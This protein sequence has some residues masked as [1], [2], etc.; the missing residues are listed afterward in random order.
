[1]AQ[2]PLTAGKG[3]G[4]LRGYGRQRG[5]GKQHGPW[6]NDTVSVL[7]EWGAQRAS[8]W[9]SLGWGWV[10]HEDVPSWHHDLDLWD[11]GFWPESLTFAFF[12]SP[13]KERFYGGRGYEHSVGYIFLR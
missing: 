4:V 7:A 6:G 1:M 3:S 11:L 5:R 2:K 9:G 12:E 13:G 8:G 10:G